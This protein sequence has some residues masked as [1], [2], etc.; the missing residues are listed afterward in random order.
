ME[1]NQTAPGQMP[2]QAWMQ[3]GRE[4]K[5]AGR[6]VEADAAFAQALAGNPSLWAAH[7]ERGVI[8]LQ[9]GDGYAAI[10]EIEAGLRIESGSAHAHLLL[11]NAWNMTGNN[12]RAMS[13]YDEAIRLD[14][15]YADAYYNRGVIHFERNELPEAIENYR[16]AVEC[17]PGFALAHS[18]LGIALESNGDPEA[19]VKSYDDAIAA[20]PEFVS[21]Y[22]N[23]SLLLL[24]NGQYE[25][26]WKLY[27][28][29]WRAGKAIPNPQLGGRDTWFGEPELKGKTLLIHSEQGLGDAIQFARYVKPAKDAGAKVV[30]QAFNP[31]VKLFGRIPGVDA[32]VG[33]GQP[34]PEFDFHCPMMTLPLAFGT[35]LESIPQDIPYLRPDKQLVSQ[36]KKKLRRSKRPR[37]GVVWKGNPKHENNKN[38]SIAFE[39]FKSVLIEGIDWVCLQKNISAAER[40]AVESMK[41]VQLVGPELG[42]FDDTCAVMSTCDL[43]ITVDTAVAH[44]SGAMGKPTWVLLPNRCDWRWLRERS[45]SPWYP[46]AC[47]FRQSEMGDW[48]GVIDRVRK[49]VAALSATGAIPDEPEV[50]HA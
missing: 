33:I 11:G 34:L 31:L 26:G 41:H 22:W 16:K 23:K 32:V 40:K 46:S 17:N 2:A 3:R 1:M 35:T 5:E 9:E 43:V 28:W 13:C 48:P 39:Q 12:D 21:G 38:R 49:G 37:V 4:L 30:M 24:R 6:T 14:P 27:E 42:D 7:V 45:D 29:R 18:N 50:E 19:A 10:K 36:W 25:E 47:L 44:L 20:D 15:K 8:R